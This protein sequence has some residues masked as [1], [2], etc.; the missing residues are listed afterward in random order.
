MKISTMIVL[1][2]AFWGATDALDVPNQN[3]RRSKEARKQI[4]KSIIEDG[5]QGELHDELEKEFVK[6]KRMSLDT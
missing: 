4:L 1:S 2:I 6:K 5:F 3:L